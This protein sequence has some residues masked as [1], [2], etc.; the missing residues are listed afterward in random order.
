LGSAEEEGQSGQLSD[1]MGAW[2]AS[3]RLDGAII[4][5]ARMQCAYP[6]TLAANLLTMGCNVSSEP[7]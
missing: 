2:G 7:A 3:K 1:D 6:F 4:V 5:R